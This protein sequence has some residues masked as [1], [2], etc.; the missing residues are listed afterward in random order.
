MEKTETAANTGRAAIDKKTQHIIEIA[1]SFLGIAYSVLLCYLIK[2]AF[3]C[4]IEYTNRIL[5]AVVGAVIAVTVGFLDYFTRRSPVTS[6]LGM[7]NMVLLFPLVMLE[8]GN[9]PLIVPTAAVTLFGFF[10]CH[11]NETAKTVFGTI[12]LLLYIIGGIA[13]Y[14]ITNF[15]FVQTEDTYIAEEASP[16][17]MFRYYTLDVKNNASGKIVVYIQPNT[18]DEENGMFRSATTIKKMLHQ[19]IKPTELVCRWDGE[20]LYINDELYFTESEYAILA[21]TGVEY[22]LTGSNWTYTKYDLDYP[23]SE[24]VND[25]MGKVKRMF[26]ERKE[27]KENNNPDSVTVSIIESE[28]EAEEEDETEAEG[29]EPE[30]TAETA[31]S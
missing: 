29:D 27:T 26:A 17:G 6:I 11:M 7:I 24:T 3:F 30:V 20:D 9:W 23:L 5:F 13:F 18:L 25:L 2:T 16:S 19:E 22:L 1:A 8:W 31:D 12:F 4:N 10:C 15:F 14:F 21:P 28:T